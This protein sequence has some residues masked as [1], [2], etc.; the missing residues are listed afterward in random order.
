MKNTMSKREVAKFHNLLKKK[1]PISDIVK[2]LKISK[3]TL[4]E[5]TPGKF[6]ELAERRAEQAALEA[7][8]LEAKEAAAESLASAAKKVAAET[9]TKAKAK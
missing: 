2:I 1:A 4:K 6:Q 8:D 9:K 7:A 5:F 3:E